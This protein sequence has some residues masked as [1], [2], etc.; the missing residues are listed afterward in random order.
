MEFDKSRVYTALDADNLKVGSKVIVAD[1]LGTLEKL[2]KIAK[3]ENDEQ[4]VERIKIIQDKSHK[5]RFFT[6]ASYN[7]AYL[8]SEPKEKEIK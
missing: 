6:S 8:I 7:L 1:D 4:W 3:S 5:F 2:V